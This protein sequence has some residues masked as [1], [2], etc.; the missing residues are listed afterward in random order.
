MPGRQ[1]FRWRA[2]SNAAL[3]TLA[4]HAPFALLLWLDDGMTSRP[5][6]HEPPV[7]TLA[8]TLL[9]LVAPIRPGRTEPV[10]TPQPG[11]PKT[12]PSPAAPAAAITLP[13]AEDS[14]SMELVTPREIDWYAQAA[15]T[16]ARHAEQA[17]NPATFSGP[18]QK[19]REPCKP[20]K[21]SFWAPLQAEPGAEP[22]RWED[23]NAAPPGSTM[24]GSTRVG[25]VQFG[26]I[27]NTIARLTD[28]ERIDGLVR[29]NRSE[30][31]SHLFD[32]MKA[33]TTPDSSVP[34][35]NHCD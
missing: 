3:L 29:E 13:A 26:A 21:S 1:P 27:V 8:I 12:V 14:P 17:D 9:P 31:N 30:P 11:A 16:A 7:R 10:E 15:A 18:V 28:S 19:M 20:R 33:G 25:V 22:P 24:I 35:P 6:R 32:D 23:M 4:A 5:V 34:D 2:R